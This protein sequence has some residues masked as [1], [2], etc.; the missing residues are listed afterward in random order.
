MKI[1]LVTEINKSFDFVSAHF[2]RKLFS[3]LLPPKSVAKLIRYDGF[4]PGDQ[5]HIQFKLPWSADWIS[6]ITSTRV[7]SEVFEFVDIGAK[8]PYGLRGWEHQHLVEKRGNDLTLIVDNMNFKTGCRV[9][10]WLYYP[11]LF[12]VFYPR[13][14]QYKTYYD[15]MIHP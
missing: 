11:I 10:D 14:A 7:N 1:R 2:D 12:M 4:S 15:E 5:I 8:L 9:M 3:F 13:K 6:Q